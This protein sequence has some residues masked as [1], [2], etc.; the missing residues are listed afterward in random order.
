MTVEDLVFILANRSY[1]DSKVT[2]RN[3]EVPD[4]RVEID[5]DNIDI[6]DDEVV[7]G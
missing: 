7:I 6:Y 4:D 5:E 2:L 1:P 3:E